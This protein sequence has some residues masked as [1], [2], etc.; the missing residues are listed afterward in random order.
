MV[1]LYCSPIPVGRRGVYSFKWFSPVSA[2]L[3]GGAWGA[4]PWRYHIL[5]WKIMWFFQLGPKF[6][7]PTHTD[8]LYKLSIS[9]QI[10]HVFMTKLEQDHRFRSLYE[11]WRC[12][13]KYKQSS[14]CLHEWGPLHKLPNPCRLVPLY[15][16]LLSS[17]LLSSM[18]SGLGG[19][20]GSLLLL[21]LA[22]EDMYYLLLLLYMYV[23]CSKYCSSSR[24]KNAQIKLTVNFFPYLKFFKRFGAKL[25]LS[26]DFLYVRKSVNIFQAIPSI[27]L[28]RFFIKE[29]RLLDHY[30]LFVWMV[31]KASHSSVPL[32]L[33]WEQN[34][35][36]LLISLISQTQS[37]NTIIQ[38]FM[39]YSEN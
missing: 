17:S 34:I 3:R 19:F 32:L 12:C 10:L 31:K 15:C 8:I 22:L 16:L 38:V 23:H 37:Y 25:H 39:L 27:F 11:V 4:A 2:T 18:D 21:L 5:S 13:M 24:I 6:P 28:F 14:L 29:E 33:N 30:Q 9:T 36:K 7:E 20:M 1:W 35:S 26:N